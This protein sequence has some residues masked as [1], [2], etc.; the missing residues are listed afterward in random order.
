MISRTAIPIVLIALAA[1]SVASAKSLRLT[2]PV[3]CKLGEDCEIIAY[4]DTDPGPGAADYTCGILSTNGNS[5]TSYAPFWE[6]LTVQVRAVAP[7]KVAAIRDG[8]MQGD[9]TAPPCGNGI[10]LDHGE[11]WTSQYCHLQAH[12]LNVQPGDRVA[13]GTP[14]GLMGRSG[15]TDEKKLHFVLRQDQA[16]VD[17]FNPDS[18]MDCTTRPTRTLWLAPPAYDQ[19]NGTDIE[20]LTPPTE[21]EEFDAGIEFLTPP[22]N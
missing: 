17:P 19:G 10:I 16:V 4:V 3:D 22:T 9:E 18:A 5:G 11:G 21:G 20:F 2:Q 12:S 8:V 7:G 14:L 6:T 15:Q 1:P 13:M